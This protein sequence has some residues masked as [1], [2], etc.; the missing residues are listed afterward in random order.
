MRHAH[1]A[2]NQLEDEPPMSGWFDQPLSEQGERELDILRRHFAHAAEAP[3][4]YTSDL[5]RAWRTAEAISMGRPVVSL[6]SLREISCGL[7]EGWPVENVKRD[8]PALWNRNEAQ[9]DPSFAW[10]GGETYAH[11]RRRVIRSISA[12]ARRHKGDAILAV[13]H[14]G[15]ISQIWGHARGLSPARWSEGRPENASLTIVEWTGGEPRIAVF[16]QRDHL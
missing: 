8:F 3:V 12:L 15:V 4:V 14:A 6:R 7:V 16:D 1:T 9:N 2:A 11:F 13:T 10:P 5:L